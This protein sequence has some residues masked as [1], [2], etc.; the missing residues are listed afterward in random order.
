[1]NGPNIFGVF[2]SKTLLVKVL[3]IIIG[4]LLFLFVGDSTF[5]QI[6]E[7]NME[8]SSKWKQD[9]DGITRIEVFWENP[10][11]N[12]YSQRQWV[13]QAVEETWCK[14]A[15]IEFVGWEKY[16]NRGKG[17]RIYIDEYSHPHTTGLGNQL[18]GVYQGMVLSFNFLG[19][20][21]CTYS[22]EFCIKAIAVHE[23]G[24]AL[25]I[26]HE[27]ERAD[28]GCDKY[29]QKFG[30][31][32]FYVTPCD[33]YSVMNYCNPKWN[34]GGQLSEYDKQ[35]IQAV[36][37]AR[38]KDLDLNNNTGLSSAIDVLGDNQI[39]ETLYLRLGDQQFIYNVN[40]SN[41]EE[42]KTFKLGSTGLYQYNISSSSLHK[43]GRLYKGYG[44][45]SIYIDNTKSYKIEV[46]AKAE[47]YPNFEVY[48]TVTDVTTNGQVVKKNNPLE[49]LPDWRPQ[50][51]TDIFLRKGQKPVS[52]LLISNAPDE[53]FYVYS[54]GI[55]MVYNKV[56]NTFFQCCQKNAPFYKNWNGKVWAWSFFRSLDNNTHE[57]YTVSSSGEVWCMGNDGIFRQYGIVTYVDF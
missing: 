46:F 37:G 1:L 5:C 17:I 36:Y 22:Q 31:G 2:Q 30:G 33:L 53:K 49:K 29:A 9:W 28:C 35:G 3:K 23:F 41:K 12:N 7:V 27:Q 8:A 44:S 6:H 13:Q 55:I 11:Q 38:K 50:T 19:A 40:A 20:F 18:D 57:T 16:N 10:S 21:K 26:A 56:S 48:I 47:A 15:N 25:G 42:I 54:D 4:I 45:G 14:N 52:L 32:G 24:H 51:N 39:W 43:D 34:N